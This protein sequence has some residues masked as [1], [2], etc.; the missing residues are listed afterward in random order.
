MLE[1]KKRFMPS[2][3]PI[4]SLSLKM[5]TMVNLRRAL[6]NVDPQYHP[7]L[8]CFAAPIDTVITLGDDNLNIW[9]QARAYKQELSDATAAGQWKR[10]VAAFHMF[11]L[12]H[13]FMYKVLG[14][15]AQTQQRVKAAA[16]SN[17]GVLEN[18]DEDK[19]VV[20]DGFRLGCLQWG[21][22]ESGM[23][24]YLFLAAS[25]QD[26][27]LNRT[28]TTPSPYVSSTTAQSLLKGIV[29]RLMVV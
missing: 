17:L 6:V 10:Q 22:E 13:D 11:R 8:H 29:H 16:I 3:S 7:C 1:I 9:A 12:G 24:H 15:L 21:I 4:V 19:A 5:E 28:L 18:D 25:T 14:R 26:G 20:K 2:P 23:G 27:S